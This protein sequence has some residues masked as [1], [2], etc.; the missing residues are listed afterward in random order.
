[1]TKEEQEDL[2]HQVTAILSDAYTP[3]ASCEDL[4]KAAGDALDLL[5]PDEEDS[6]PDS[7]DHSEDESDEE[8]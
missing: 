5:D 6:D 2:I 1:M 8:S 7:K 3:D 4:A